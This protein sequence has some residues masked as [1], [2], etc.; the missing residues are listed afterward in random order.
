MNNISN[1]VLLSTHSCHFVKSKENHKQQRL[2]G[3]LVSSSTVHTV[4]RCSKSL[5]QHVIISCHWALLTIASAWDVKP[6]NK[7]P[8]RDNIRFQIQIQKRINTLIY[9]RA[10]WVV[11]FQVLSYVFLIILENYQGKHHGA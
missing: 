9:H 2:W 11:P 5:A 1:K 4:C 3:G 8:V 10:G 6:Q 7:V